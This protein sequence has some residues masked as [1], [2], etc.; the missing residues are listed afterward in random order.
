MRFHGSSPDYF[1]LALVCLLTVAGLVI[2]S[3]A[4]S[5]LGKIRFND[6]YYY[7]KHQLL[8]GLS[9]G[10][11]GFFFGFL[12]P[13]R[14]Y[15]RYAFPLLLVS[16][17]LLALVFTKLGVSSGGASRWLS[18]GSF[19]FQPSELLKLTYVLYLAA[20]LANPKANRV[21]DLREGIIPFLIVSGVVA[22]LL[23]FQPA[24]SVVVILLAVGCAMYFMSGL[25]MKHLLGM[26]LVGIAVIGIVVWA[27]PYRRARIL[28]F[29][30]PSDDTR[31]SS[32]QINQ[33][34]TAIGSGR[35]WGMGYGASPSKVNYLPAPL[36]DSIFA[37]AAQELG[38]IGS[39]SLAFLFLLL[40]FRM[41]WIAKHTRERFGQLLLVGFALVIGF[42]SLVNMGAISGLFPLTGVSL[43]FVSY[44]GTALAVFLTMSGIALNVSKY[45]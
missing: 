24:T 45:S 43:P 12:V 17:V 34:L 14:H 29:L 33:T 23:F 31:G 16:L 36:D 32:Y 1:L 21:R 5:D 13:Y 10:L 25:P 19:T 27:T 20:W 11:A 6:S 2:L 28:T 37:V 41:L 30:H 18:L 26:V 42:Q 3:S 4:S 9:L 22:S 7:L 44:G 15:R 38:F 39:A 40:V 35:L 8:Y